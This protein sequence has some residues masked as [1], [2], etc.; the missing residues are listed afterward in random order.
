MCK[1]PQY[2]ASESEVEGPGVVIAP[3]PEN[4][5]ERCKADLGLLSCI[6]VSKFGDYLPLYRQNGIFEREGVNTPRALPGQA[7]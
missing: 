1:G 4:P 3:M 2:G 7:G 6:T 5:I